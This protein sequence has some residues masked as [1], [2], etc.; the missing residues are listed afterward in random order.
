MSLLKYIA[1]GLFLT[2]EETKRFI[3]T[4]PRRY[5]RFTIAK[6]NSLDRRLI[7]QPARQVKSIQRAVLK[8]I[9]EEIKV[10][11]CAFA[12]EIDRDIKKNASIHKAN[13]YLL[14]MD[15]KNFFLSIKPIN[16]LSVIRAHGVELED[17]DVFVLENL[18]F[19]KLRRNSPLRLSIG[20]P[21]SPFISNAVMF[22]FDKML[23]EKCEQMG[24]VYTRYA[25]DLT[26]STNR[27]G[28]LF[29]VPQLVREMLNETNLRNIKINHEKTIFSSK[30]FNRHVTGVTLANDG[31]LSL[32]RER[33]RLLRSKVDYYIKGL[34]SPKEILILKGELGYAKFIEPEFIERVKQKY[35][36]DVVRQIQKYNI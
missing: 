12:Y 27:K 25:D 20:A 3:I 34:L 31:F 22:F 33:K 32:G 17:D 29:G 13:S 11:E 36:S 9:R 35:G 7:A 10:H 24:V 15:F 16:F 5:K 1:D 2:E 30:K 28:I 26:F 23:S 4:V 6:R 8:Y 18:F 14:K 21:S 19:W